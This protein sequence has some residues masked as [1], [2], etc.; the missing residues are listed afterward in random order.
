MMDF[1]DLDSCNGDAEHDMRV[2]FDNYEN[3]TPLDVFNE[4]DIDNFID[5]L[6]DWN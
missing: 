2:D 6:N 3:T 1:N 5:N 4:S